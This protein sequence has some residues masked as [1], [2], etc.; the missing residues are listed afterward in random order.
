VRRSF[1]TYYYTKEAPV[2]GDVEMHG[3]LF[4][5]RPDEKLRGYVLMPAERIT[6]GAAN[7]ARAVAGNGRRLAGKLLRSLGLK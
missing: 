6:R 4:R 3:T 2:D 7:A 5:A 1:A